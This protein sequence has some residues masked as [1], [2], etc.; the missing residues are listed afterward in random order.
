MLG[1]TS[2]KYVF[3]ILVNVFF[4]FMGMI[5]DPGASILI[6]APIF[7]PIA[8]TFGIQPLH[9]A[10]VMLVNLNLGLITPPVGTCLYVEAPIAKISLER[11]AKAVLPFVGVEVIALMIMTFVPELILFLPRMLGI[12]Y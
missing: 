1:L 3:L 7:L 8:L 11:F 2:N 10:I 6:L 9:F 4:L 12:F 5:M